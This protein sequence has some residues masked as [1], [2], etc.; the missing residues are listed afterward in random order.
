MH[1]DPSESSREPREP[2]LDPEQRIR[3]LEHR[4]AALER[5]SEYSGS[6]AGSCLIIVLWAV[7]LG[8]L[9]AIFAATIA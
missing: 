4:L 6:C 8:L 1:D 2:G 9:L 3:E 5:E 7:A